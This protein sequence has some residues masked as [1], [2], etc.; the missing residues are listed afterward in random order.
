MGNMEG[1]AQT[2]P[3][4]SI[5]PARGAGGADAT[6]PVMRSQGMDGVQTL[7]EEVRQHGL[8][9][10]NFL[11]LLHVLIGRRITQADGTLISQGLTWR[12]LAGRL[13]LVRWD[14]DAV[15]ELGL[16]PADLPPRDR[17]RFWYAAIAHARV[18]SPAAA[19]AGNRLAAKL[20]NR[21]YVIGPPPGQ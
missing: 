10:G 18:D 9:D 12:D 19:E 4:H 13:K 14:K 15:R 8:A 11:G 20:S 17:Q 1:K 5:R 2:L 6:E 16:D 3:D 21:G 7:L